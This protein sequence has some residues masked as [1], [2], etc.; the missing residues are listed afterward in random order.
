MLD[1]KFKNIY[2][3]GNKGLL[4][5]TQKYIQYLIITYNRNNFKNN[6]Y[7]Y[8]QLNH[9]AVHLKHSKSTILQ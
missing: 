4:Y 7:V 1:F 9:L 3:T 2:A 5:S 8:I 6:I